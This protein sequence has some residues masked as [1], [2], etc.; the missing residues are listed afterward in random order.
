MP[1]DFNAGGL[2]VE[3]T[4]FTV[5]YYD[6]AAPETELTQEVGS[7]TTNEITVGTLQGGHEYR[8]WVI[9]NNIYGPGTASVTH[10][11]VAAT[12]PPQPEAPTIT[13][14][15]TYVKIAW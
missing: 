4:S 3:I 15:G 6:L 13:Y 2:G 9:A 5:N 11:V 1:V 8:F 7:P 10:D 12:F 14:Q